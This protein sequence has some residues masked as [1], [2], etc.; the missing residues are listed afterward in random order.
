MSQ[1]NASLTEP[2]S[3]VHSLTGKFH[4]GPDIAAIQRIDKVFE[5]VQTARAQKL[6]T[7]RDNLH[8]RT[9]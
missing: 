9:N 8:R 2:R 5:N 3:I 4:A 1:N 6:A 7:S